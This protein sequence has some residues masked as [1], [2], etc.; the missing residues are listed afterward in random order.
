MT[1]S[2][3]EES[4]RRIAEALRARATGAGRPVPLAGYTTAGPS[5]APAEH[6]SAEDDRGVAEEL[7]AALAAA[8]MVLL[9]ALLGGIL[10]GVVLALV[11][12][13]APGSFPSFG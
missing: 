2:T 1:V 6:A 3:S 10:L 12:V 7:R 9:Y 8:R 5:E 13:L 11:S 4:E